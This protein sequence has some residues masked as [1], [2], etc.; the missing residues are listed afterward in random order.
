[1]I[2]G[3]LLASNTVSMGTPFVTCVAH[4]APAAV[5]HPAA[6]M[7]NAVPFCSSSKKTV[8][9]RAGVWFMMPPN[10]CWLLFW[11]VEAGRAV[12]DD[13][14]LDAD[15][16]DAVDALF[17]LEEASSMAIRGRSGSSS[18]SGP[19][20]MSCVISWAVLTLEDGAFTINSTREAGGKRKCVTGMVDPG[21][22]PS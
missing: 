18:P 2:D 3:G 21:W 12:S 4:W 20:L 8:R 22:V 9:V 19:L 5:T 11:P 7:K 1:M 17:L 10:I 6:L 14:E 16:V 13:D 15:E